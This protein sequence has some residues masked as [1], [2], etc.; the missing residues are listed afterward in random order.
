MTN[1]GGAGLIL[2][3]PGRDSVLLVC[4]LRSKK[5]GFPKGHREKEDTDPIAT[6]TRECL[7]ETGIDPS[8]YTIHGSPFRL[9]K[10]SGAYIFYYATAH[11]SNLVVTPQ[12]SEIETI[13][14]IPIPVLLEN[15]MNG[16]KYLRVWIADMLTGSKRKSV[17]LFQQLC[18]VSSESPRS[19]HVVAHA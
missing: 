19:P 6:A 5:W 14:W 11:S 1:Y 13:A 16:N 7:E 9:A 15:P 8:Q 12:A 2:L 18:G 10:S 3:S 17:H 4:D